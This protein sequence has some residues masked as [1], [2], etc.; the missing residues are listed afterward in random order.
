MNTVTANTAPTNSGDMLVPTI[1]TM[2][3]AWALAPNDQHIACALANLHWT[4][5]DHRRAAE[6][7]DAALAAT[8]A[9]IPDLLANAG[10]IRMWQKHPLDALDLVD[11]ALDLDPDHDLAQRIHQAAMVAA[12]LHIEPGLPP[13][14]HARSLTETFEENAGI[15]AFWFNTAPRPDDK[16][17]FLVLTIGNCGAIWFASALNLHPEIFAGCGVDH[18]IE[19][20]FRYTMHKDGERL[21]RASRPEHYRNGATQ[22]IMEPI[23]ARHGLDFDFPA[24]RYRRLPWY[25]LDELEEMP[26]AEEY[27]SLG[28]VHALMPLQFA[29]FYRRDP[30]ILEGRRVVNANMIRHPLPRVESFI[31]ALIHYNIDSP[32]HRG[33][34]D[35]Y[36]TKHPDERRAL[37]RRYG[38]DFADPRARAVLLTFRVIHSVPFVANELKLF[39]AMRALKMEDLQEDPD[40]FADAV[41]FLTQGSVAVTPDYLDR[42]FLPENLG[43]GRRGAIADGTRPPGPE[44]QW[45]EW[46]DFERDEF[47]QCCLRH[48][49]ADIYRPHGYDFSF[50]D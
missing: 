26:F 22:E 25:V 14:D 49:I 31:K 42:V 7:I 37:E 43:T 44:A 46:S 18:P 8:D 9:P 4:H 30:T 50:L 17:N 3:H 11:R 1:E 48:G 28:S 39:S 24:R 47:R 5:G 2:E 12:K 19:T 16:R 35:T 6:I 41:T 20:C 36:F 29:Q 32:T 34:V 21:V 15:S 33:M 40:Y 10:V 23:L 38:I 13:L 27:T 45:A